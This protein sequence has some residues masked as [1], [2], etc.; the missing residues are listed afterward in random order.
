MQTTIRQERTDAPTLLLHWG[1]VITLTFSLLTGLRLAA[2]AE[3]SVWARTLSGLLLQ[4]T[5]TRWHVWAA[6]ALTLLALGYVVYLWRARLAARV[7]LD[8][9]RRHGLRAADRRQ[10]WSALNVLVYWLAFALILVA[11]GSGALL[12]FAPGLLPSAILLWLHQAVA[13]A[14]LG[15]VALHVLAQL[16]LGGLPQLLKI[17]RPRLAYGSAAAAALV[18]ALA[19]GGL[20]YAVD[21]SVSAGE[22]VIARTATP[23]TLDGDPEDAAWRA[24]P[25]VSVHTSRGANFPGGESE[26]RIRAV[27]DGER[28][29]LL[30]EW[31][32]PTRSQKHLPL[33][34]TEQGWK[35]LQKEYGIE[36]ED[37]YYEDKF[38][39]MLAHSPE[40]AAAGTAHMGRQPLDGKPPAKGGRGLHYTS[41]GS[42]VDA[43]HWKSVRSGALDQIDD[44]YFGPPLEP[45]ADPN[46]RYPGGYTQDPKS[47]GGF[48]M[49]WEKFSDGPLKPLRL[50]K[51]PALLQRMGKI[52]LDPDSGDDGLFFLAWE[53]TVPYAPELDT[54]PLG[55]VMPSVLTEGPFQGDRGD[56]SAH[57][58]WRDGWWRLEVSRKLDTGSRFDVALRPGEPVYLW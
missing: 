12:Y 45:D 10:R 38:G 51:D 24:V 55:T 14:V 28:V 2:D 1:M 16:A 57:A 20:L 17:L 36:D 4:G 34:K 49:N 29:Y 33:V 11:A 30:F 35:V 15:Y 39:V 37:D 44:N 19:G 13:W 3:D 46:K 22:L 54:Y 50:P 8:G 9:V 56:V 47:G 27:H 53:D 31:T 52:D 26:V 25:A 6:Y 32:D 21:R 7:A 5:V 23:P 48:K 42:I 58:S 40:I 41:D 43:W 18:I